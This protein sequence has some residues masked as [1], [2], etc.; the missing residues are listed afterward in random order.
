[1]NRPL[2]GRLHPALAGPLRKLR[3]AWLKKREEH[4][5]IC[6]SA[7]AKKAQEANQNV[8]YFQKMAAI[9]RSERN[10]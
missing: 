2:L 7:E 3:A 1:M 8:R 5:L 4:Y 10:T 6:A 9:A